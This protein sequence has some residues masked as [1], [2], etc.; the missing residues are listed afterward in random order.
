MENKIDKIL[1][2]ISTK[3]LGRKTKKTNVE[4]LMNYLKQEEEKF[5]IFLD[6]ILS[7]VGKGSLLTHDGL[8]Q[9]LKLNFPYSVFTFAVQINV[10][11]LKN[12]LVPIEEDNSEIYQTVAEFKK[13]A[14][15]V[16]EE[17]YVQ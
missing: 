2:L 8:M 3:N 10:N 1:Q 13:K 17:V 11:K 9:L 15:Q 6:K 5:E 7:E 14:S 4:K 16:C 12:K